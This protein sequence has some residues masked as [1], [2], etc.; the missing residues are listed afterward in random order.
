MTDHP[1]GS[2]QQAGFSQ[3]ASFNINI[4]TVS[5]IVIGC[6]ISWFREQAR[7]PNA[8]VVNSGQKVATFLQ[9]WF[10]SDDAH[11]T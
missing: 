8:M 5:M 1:S 4:V 9:S 3:T 2:L 10:A 6:I 7:I 11:F